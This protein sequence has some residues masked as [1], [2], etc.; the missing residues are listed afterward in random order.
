MP[1]PH[2]FEHLPL[3]M[4]YQGQARLPRG[5]KSNPQTAANKTNRIA[6][7]AGL[8]SSGT[9]LSTA[10]KDRI[11][12]NQQ[13]GSPVVPK[14]MPVLLEVDP[15]LDLDVLRDKFAF[16]IVAEQEE[17]FVI[18]ASEDLDLTAFLQMVDSFSTATYGSARIASIHRLLDD[19]DQEERLRRILS[20]TLLR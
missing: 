12:L 14:G 19:P 7:S 18:V 6:H 9:A 13:A 20:D 10:W 2:N 5:G 3:V 16:E 8:R 4:R 11:Q 17:G 1:P 15:G